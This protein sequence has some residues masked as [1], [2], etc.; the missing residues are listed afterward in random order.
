MKL[1][2]L[3]VFDSIISQMNKAS[4]NDLC[5]IFES[6]HDFCIDMRLKYNKKEDLFEVFEE[7]NYN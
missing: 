5:D 1:T 6:A 7:E 4:N 2:K 3:Q